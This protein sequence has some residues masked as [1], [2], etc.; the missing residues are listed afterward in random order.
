MVRRRRAMLPNRRG[1]T[2]PRLGTAVRLPRQ[3]QRRVAK[4]DGS[5]QSHPPEAPGTSGL[6]RQHLAAP[7]GV[8]PPQPRQELVPTGA[9]LV[10]HPSLMNTGEGCRTLASQSDAEAGPALSVNEL[11]LGKPSAMP[12]RTSHSHRSNGLRKRPSFSK[13]LANSNPVQR[14]PC[15]HRACLQRGRARRQAIRLRV[16]DRRQRPAFLWS[17]SR[18]M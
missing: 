18:L 13:V 11:Q 4:G 6:A 7:E 10:H 1:R 8:D 3:L 15:G 14:S 2:Q 12:G 17:V 5:S 16:E 9:V